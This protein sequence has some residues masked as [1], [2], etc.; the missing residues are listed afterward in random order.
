MPALSRRPALALNEVWREV[1][2][3]ALREAM[4]G[5][6]LNAGLQLLDIDEDV[7][8][9]PQLIGHHRGVTRHRGNHTYANAA[10]LQ[11]CH[12]RTEGAIA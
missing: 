5:I 12:Q 2:I 3:I 4:V 6:A 7:G 9:P 10:T 1:T 11:R 8:L